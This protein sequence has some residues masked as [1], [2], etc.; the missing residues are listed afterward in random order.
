M[1]SP[2]TATGRNVRTSVAADA[3]AAPM[4]ARATASARPRV[5]RV[6]RLLDT[7]T[8]VDIWAA[9]QTSFGNPAVSSGWRPVALRARLATG[10]PLSGGAYERCLRSRHRPRRRAPP[11][12]GARA[13]TCVYRPRSRSRAHGRSREVTMSARGTLRALP[14]RADVRHPWGEPGHG[15]PPAGPG[16]EPAEGAL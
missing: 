10:V 1:A 9:T 12:I 5:L 8:S 3:G 16:R 7:V 11:G 14:L 13:P 4:A 6:S 15:G 2:L